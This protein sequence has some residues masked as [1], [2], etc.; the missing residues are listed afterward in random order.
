LYLRRWFA[1]AA[2]ALGKRERT[3]TPTLPCMGVQAK[4]AA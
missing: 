1:S 3:H 4:V 2:K